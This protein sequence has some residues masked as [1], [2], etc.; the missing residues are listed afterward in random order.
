LEALASFFSEKKLTCA[1]E[2]QT[3][4]EVEADIKVQIALAMTEKCKRTC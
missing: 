4:K 1:I 2:N 3:K